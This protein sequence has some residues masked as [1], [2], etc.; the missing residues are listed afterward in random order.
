MLALVIFA[1]FGTLVSAQIT[2]PDPEIDLDL[3][4]S[5]GNFQ[6]SEMIH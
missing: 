2:V 5:E 4:V 3:I 1:D 6:L